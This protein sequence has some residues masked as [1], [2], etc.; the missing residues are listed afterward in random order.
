MNEQTDR[1]EVFEKEEASEFEEFSKVDEIFR[2][3]HE[4]ILGG[5]AKVLEEYEIEGYRVTGVTFEPPNPC[6]CL[7]YVRYVSGVGIEAGIS[8]FDD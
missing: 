7:P 3:E 2:E 8:C 1:E 6:L 4:D 5:M